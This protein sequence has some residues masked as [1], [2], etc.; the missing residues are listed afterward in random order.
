MQAVNASPMQQGF[1][2]VTNIGISAGIM[3]HSLKGLKGKGG[4]I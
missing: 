2:D 3:K 1:K 4:F